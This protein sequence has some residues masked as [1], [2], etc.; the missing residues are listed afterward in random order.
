MNKDSAED[1]NSHRSA[2]EFNLPSKINKPKPDANGFTFHQTASL[3]IFGQK[4]EDGLSSRRLKKKKSSYKSF[5]EVKDKFGMKKKASKK[6]SKT[7]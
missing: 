2:I 6:I 4:S 3:G 1:Q 5:N 7:K